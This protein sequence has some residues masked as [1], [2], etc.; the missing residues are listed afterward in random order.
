MAIE[1][2][3]TT[4]KEISKRRFQSFLLSTV[5][6]IPLLT[7]TNDAM[8]NKKNIIDISRE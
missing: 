1:V 8:Y 3:V 7:S 6:S 2:I 5:E 4:M